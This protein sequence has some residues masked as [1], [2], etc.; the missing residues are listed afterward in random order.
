MSERQ[1]PTTK[2]ELLSTNAAAWED[3]LAVIDKHTT[4]QLIDLRDA[5]GWS[6]KDHLAHLAAWERSVLFVLRDGLSQWEGLGVDEQTYTTRRDDDF[7]RINDLIHSREQDRPL[8]DVLLELRSINEAMATTIEAM[9]D[10]DLQKPVDDYRHDG[11]STPVLRWISG[12]IW[13]HYDE[14]RGNIVKILAG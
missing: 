12:D 10:D 9:S 13:D 11:D 14:H 2:Q 3:L 4:E 8:E 1:E 6:A 5:A 7:F